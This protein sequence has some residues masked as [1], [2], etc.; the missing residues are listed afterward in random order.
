MA[1]LFH[2]NAQNHARMAAN[3]WD[4]KHLRFFSK[5]VFASKLL[6]LPHVPMWCCLQLSLF[7]KKNSWCRRLVFASD[8]NVYKTWETM[9]QTAWGIKTDRNKPQTT[10]NKTIDTNVKSKRCWSV[11]HYPRR[12][13]ILQSFGG[14]FDLLWLDLRVAERATC[15]LEQW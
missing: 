15:Q 8:L 3:V 13:H 4:R 11:T 14:E 9:R 12:L 10:V 2:Q 7:L 6:K 1:S 5:G